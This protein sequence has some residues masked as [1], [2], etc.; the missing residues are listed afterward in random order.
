MSLPRRIL[1]QDRCFFRTSAA[2]SYKYKKYLMKFQQ[3]LEQTTSGNRIY[4]FFIVNIEKNKIRITKKT[5]NK[6]HRR[7]HYPKHVFSGFYQIHEPPTNRPTDSTDPPTNR[8]LTT[9][10]LTHRPP[11][12][13]LTESI[14]IFRRLDN[15]NIFIFQN[16]RTARKIYTVTILQY[17]I[18]KVYWFP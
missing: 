10:L 6:V 7:N 11:T 18:Q 14:I 9:Y 8:P 2:T 3:T 1:Q 15:R 4:F 5:S 16:T 17:I 12:Q 13:R